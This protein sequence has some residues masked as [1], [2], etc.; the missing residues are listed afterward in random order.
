MYICGKLWER[1]LE[2]VPEWW[3]VLGD[4]WEVAIAVA[5]ELDGPVVGRFNSTFRANYGEGG[6]RMNQSD[7]WWCVRN[8]KW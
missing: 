3:I 6:W 4:K 8:G 1:W 7:G 5:V 2:N